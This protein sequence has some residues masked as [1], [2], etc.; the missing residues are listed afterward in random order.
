MDMVFEKRPFLYSLDIVSLYTNIIQEHAT[1][2]ITEFM[3]KHLDSFHL[4]INALNTL[5]KIMCNTNVYQ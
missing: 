4:D 3:S 1:Q 2:L 5:I